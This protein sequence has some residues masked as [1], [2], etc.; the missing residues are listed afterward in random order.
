MRECVGTD[1]P[2]EDRFSFSAWE[3]VPWWH[4]R[5]WFLRNWVSAEP[6]MRRQ[7]WE[8]Y[9]LGGQYDCQWAYRDVQVIARQALEKRFG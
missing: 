3:P 4:Y 5:S 8:T 6:L 7:E 2:N 1:G 9:S